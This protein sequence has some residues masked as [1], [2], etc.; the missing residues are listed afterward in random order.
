MRKD[1]KKAGDTGLQIGARAHVAGSGAAPGSSAVVPRLLPAGDGALVIELG[2]AIAPEI[3]A[4]VH[5]LDAAIGRAGIRCISE[6]VPTYRSIL[7][8][9][10]AL[11]ADAGSLSERLLALAAEDHSRDETT[12]RRW[13]IP[14]AYGG[15]H[16]ID[17]EDVAKA[18]GLSTAEVVALHAAADYAVYMIGFSPGF[19]YLGGLAEALHLPRRTNPRLKTPAG[20]VMVGGMQAAISP[21]AMPSG[22]HIL[23]TTPA[24]LF[25]PA[26][27]EPF[28]LRPGDRVRFQPVSVADFERLS[29]AAR[30]AGWRPDHDAAA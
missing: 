21:L 27:A 19:A 8:Y 30:H 6:T 3:N 24:R 4:R 2:E 22:W 13:H 18:T 11:A 15:A 14:V 23:G 5:A 7:V 17:L 10:D 29:Q 20:S 28:L 1:G 26:A 16:G 9:F 12:A 25:E